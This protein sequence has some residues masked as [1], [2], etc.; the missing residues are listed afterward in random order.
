[1]EL[2]DMNNLFLKQIFSLH[3]LIL[4]LIIS[5]SCKKEIYI[6]LSFHFLITSKLRYKIFG[7]KYSFT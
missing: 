2:S 5:G 6:I 4:F 7:F 3:L 1:M